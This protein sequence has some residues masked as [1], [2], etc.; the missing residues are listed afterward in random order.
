VEKVYK[1]VLVFTPLE[2]ELKKNYGGFMDAMDIFLKVTFEKK[3]L[4]TKTLDDCGKKTCM[5]E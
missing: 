2:G 3:T 5:E 1:K 4:K